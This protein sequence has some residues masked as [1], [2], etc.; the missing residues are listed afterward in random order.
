MDQRAE[1]KHTSGK[2]KDVASEGG[3]HY[4]PKEAKEKLLTLNY[5][6]RQIN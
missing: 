1:T 4:S 6:M 3:H 5:S 2:I